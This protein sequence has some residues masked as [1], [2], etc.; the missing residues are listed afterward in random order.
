MSPLF[1]NKISVY[2]PDWVGHNFGT[3]LPFHLPPNPFDFRTKLLTLVTGFTGDDD[4]MSCHTWFNPL[5]WAEA[6]HI[7][8]RFASVRNS[9]QS[10]EGNELKW[11]RMEKVVTVDR[12]GGTWKLFMLC[13][14][15]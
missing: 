2:V 3:H 15:H 1:K 6:N 9:A 8:Y 12:R 14:I 13:E 5:R 11:Y 10:I 4:I 7:W